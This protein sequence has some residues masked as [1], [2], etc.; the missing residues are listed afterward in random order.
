MTLT[1]DK[2]TYRFCRCGLRLTLVLDN[3]RVLDMICPKWIGRDGGGHD[4]YRKEKL[5]T[6]RFCKCG[7]K[8]IVGIDD[9]EALV[10]ICP[11]WLDRTGVKHEL[12]REHRGGHNDP[13]QRNYE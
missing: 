12:Y 13:P 3:E 2:K 9:A 1:T 7:K 6:G 11:G 5:N 10:M 8:M 4:I